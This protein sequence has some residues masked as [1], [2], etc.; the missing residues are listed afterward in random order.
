[1][2]AFVELMWML[3]NLPPNRPLYFDSGLWQVR[4]DDMKDV[5]FQQNVNESTYEFIRRVYDNQEEY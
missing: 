5:L 1:M 2:D 3:D 4:T